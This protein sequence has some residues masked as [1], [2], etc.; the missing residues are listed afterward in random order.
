MLTGQTELYK[1]RYGCVE[2]RSASQCLVLKQYTI[3][4][5][6]G[7]SLPKNR[8]TSYQGS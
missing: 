1:K 6:L 2:S 4:E 3:F 8:Q 7:R 5:A